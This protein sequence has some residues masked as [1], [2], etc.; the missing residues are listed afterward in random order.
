LIAP[1]T[2]IFYDKE[3][4][5]IGTKGYLEIL[6]SLITGISQ[7]YLRD[8]ESAS[9]AQKMSWAS[10]RTTTRQEDLTYSLI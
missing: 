8:Y 4:V 7:P 1:Q 3:W 10:R 6:I 5:E 9:V 2:L